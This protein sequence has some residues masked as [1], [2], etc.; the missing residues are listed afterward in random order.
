MANV[1]V[2]GHHD[3]DDLS[4]HRG[5]LAVEGVQSLHLDNGA[6][7]FSSLIPPSIRES[8]RFE[9]PHVLLL[10]SHGHG[11]EVTVT[12]PQTKRS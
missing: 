10:T 9:V 1:E 7:T 12:L 5:T 4:I 8:R 3:P 11:V 6:S 2:S